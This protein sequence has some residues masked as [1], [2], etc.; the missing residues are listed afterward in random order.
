MPE[1]FTLQGI[2]ETNA[3]VELRRKVRNTNKL[4][5]FATGKRVTNLYS[6]MIMQANN[7]SR[8]SFRGRR[9]L[10]RKKRHSVTD[11]DLFTNSHMAHFHA[12]GILS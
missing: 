7:V 12:L 3:A 1:L 4:Q 9:T 5:V 10:T 11:P 8:E 6:P 2:L